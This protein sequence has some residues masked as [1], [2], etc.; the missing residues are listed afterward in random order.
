M[1]GGRDVR[2]SRNI[3]GAEDFR[4][5]TTGPIPDIYIWGSWLSNNHGQITNFWLGI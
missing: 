2:D 5:I 4:C 3:V 1:D